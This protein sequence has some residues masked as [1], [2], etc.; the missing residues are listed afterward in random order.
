M[1]EDRLRQ[2]HQLL[3]RAEANA[4][5]LHAASDDA[6]AVVQ[7][8]RTAIVE[9]KKGH[10]HLRGLPL[11]FP[12]ALA[13][14]GAV[15]RWAGRNSTAAA[16]IGAGATVAAA[17]AVGVSPLVVD[18][19]ADQIVTAPKPPAISRPHTAHTP[20]PKRRGPPTASPSPSV[21]GRPGKRARPTLDAGTRPPLKTH[22]L[23]L[24]TRAVPKPPKV[25]PPKIPPVRPPKAPLPSWPDGY[26][27]PTL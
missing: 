4:E 19:P 27:T 2:L 12:A 24:K 7:D 13:T 25:K 10:R 9:E 23:P 14:A 17:T 15:V 20:P 11:L 22:E 1:Q 5:R 18:P 8:I 21:P 26:T 16:T 6:D 3:P